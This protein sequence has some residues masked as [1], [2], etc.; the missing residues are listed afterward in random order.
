M[1][2]KIFYILVLIISFSWHIFAQNMT[3]GVNRSLFSDHKAS[4]VGDAVTIM[5]IEQSSAENNATTKALRDSKV[6]LSGAASS[7]TN[8]AVG[9]GLSGNAGSGNNFSG[10]GSTSSKGNIQAK[11]SARIIEIDENGNLKIEGKRILKVNDE[12]TTIKIS[13]YIRPQDILPDNSVYS[14]K[15]SD[16]EITF[17]G[18]G[19]VS[20]A[21]GPGWITKLLRW[22]F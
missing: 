1:K 12:K 14:Y 19:I 17:E 4:Q 2:N 13:G 20:S 8:P 5:I 11:I 15:V 22:L 9:G 3:E 6:S 21:Q 16:A 18:D 7:T 10:S